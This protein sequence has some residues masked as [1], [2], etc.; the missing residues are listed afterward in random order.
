MPVADQTLIRWIVSPSIRNWTRRL[1][2]SNDSVSPCSTPGV[3]SGATTW[4]AIN[5]PLLSARR[6]A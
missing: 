6:R 3:T 4:S 2:A 1:R 5:S